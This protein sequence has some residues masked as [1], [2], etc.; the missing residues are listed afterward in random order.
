M[1]KENILVLIKRIYT[2]FIVLS[3]FNMLKI[4]KFKKMEEIK[5]NIGCGSV[6]F[7]N[8]INIDMEPNADLILDIRKGLPFEDNSVDFIYNE[9]FIE[10]LTSEE[11]KNAVEEFYRTLK[12]GG[13][14]RIATP[15][16]DYVIKKYTKDWKNQDWLSWPS[17]KFIDTRGQMINISFRE[18]GHKYLYNEED[19]TFLLKKSGF[20]NIRKQ[21][22]NESNYSEVSGRETRKDSK[23]ILEAEK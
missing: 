3:P 1:N 10:H 12:N 11:G 9:H 22:L 8:W 16:L 7:T 15:D 18:W 2:K 13:V 20:K 14:L 17:F 23:L 19:L 4:R 5:L 6:K 21:N